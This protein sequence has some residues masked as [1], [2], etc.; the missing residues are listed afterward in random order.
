M[1]IQSRCH[2]TGGGGQV[3]VEL[4]QHWRDISC[5]EPTTLC[6]TLMMQR[7]EFQIEMVIPCMVDSGCIVPHV[8]SCSAT[9]VM[10]YVQF[11]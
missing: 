8:V 9:I 3:G 4:L 1:T 11:M 2:T 5:F 7:G 10:E 6:T